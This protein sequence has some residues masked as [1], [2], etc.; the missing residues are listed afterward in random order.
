MFSAVVTK[1]DL[2][3]FTTAAKVQNQ[4]FCYIVKINN[5]YLQKRSWL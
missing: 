2:N 5:F 4:L 1:S 3:N